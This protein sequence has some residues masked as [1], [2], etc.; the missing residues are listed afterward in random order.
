MNIDKE[1]S[2]NSFLSD[3]ESN[4]PKNNND[5]N[6]QIRKSRTVKNPTKFKFK[7]VQKKAKRILRK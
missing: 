7:K 4:I 5:D 6:E 1:K 2:N 3:D